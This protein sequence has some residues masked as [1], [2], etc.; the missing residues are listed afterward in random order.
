MGLSLW[1][2]LLADQTRAEP[3]FL[4]EA[5]RRNT[6]L[7]QAMLGVG[8]CS[9]H[10]RRTRNRFT[11]LSA[12]LSANGVK[13]F[14]EPSDLREGSS[15]SCQMWGYS[16]LHHLRRFAAYIALERPMYVPARTL[17]QEEDET[18]QKY[19]SFADEGTRSDL[20]FR[21]LMLHSDAEGFY[22]PENFERVIHPGRRDYKALGGP[23]GSA[24]QLL[25]ECEALAKALKLPLTLDP[26]S[27]EVWS[28]ADQPGTGD[29]KWK[30]FGI[31][32][33]SCV[34]LAHA[35]KRAIETGA[36]VVFC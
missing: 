8:L 14:V 34:R 33:F 16:G 5:L 11:R 36:A 4:P 21:H 1:V 32:S 26:E 28:A 30:Q 2:G 9:A 12:C 29:V 35:C 18:V 25:A 15:F 6:R 23:I 27:E 31:E 19:Y 3:S 17:P 20:P 22:V 24:N 7:R 13:S 10:Y